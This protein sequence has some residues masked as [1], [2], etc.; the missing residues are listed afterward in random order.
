MVTPVNPDKSITPGTDRTTQSNQRLN[1][2]QGGDQ[3]SIA[4]SQT[5]AH[6]ESRLDVDSARQLYQLENKGSE[7]IGPGIETHEQARTLLNQLLQQFTASPE[8][9]SKIHSGESNTLLAKLLAAAPG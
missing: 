1:V 2:E 9:A 7:T 8:Q 5:A 3:R 4:E 6:T